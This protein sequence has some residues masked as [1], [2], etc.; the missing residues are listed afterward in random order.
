MNERVILL[1]VMISTKYAMRLLLK[2]LAKI[3]VELIDG[4]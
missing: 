2:P 3:A 4:N 1:R